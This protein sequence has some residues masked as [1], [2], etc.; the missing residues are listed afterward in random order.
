MASAKIGC[1]EKSLNH[2]DSRFP[3]NDAAA[4][5]ENIGVVVLPREPCGVDVMR[6]GRANARHFICRDG[7]PNSR[8]ANGDS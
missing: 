2:L 1:G 5:R 8:A 6:Q 4:E 7:N 3:R